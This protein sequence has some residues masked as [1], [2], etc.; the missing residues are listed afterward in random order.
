MKK[1][2]TLLATSMFVVASYAQSTFSLVRNGEALANGAEVVVTTYTLEYDWSEYGMG[3]GVSFDSGI[4]IKNVSGGEAS[5]V[6]RLEG[7]Q[8]ASNFSICC[9][10]QCSP[11]GSEGW[12]EKIGVLAAGESVDTQI[13]DMPSF[14]ALAEVAAHHSICKLNVY[15]ANNP[16]DGITVT[17]VMKGATDSGLDHVA[18]ENT[19]VVMG[20]SLHYNFDNAEGRMLRVFDISGASVMSQILGGGTGSVSLSQLPKGIYLYKVEGTKVCGKMIVK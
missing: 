3:V 15:N 13:H 20:R 12:V 1:L 19:V 18:S 9:G 2:F 10:G 5:F 4:H 8:N 11:I 6:A 7:V 16:S 17:L 14:D